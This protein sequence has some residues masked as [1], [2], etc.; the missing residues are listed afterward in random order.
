MLWAQASQHW[1][2]AAKQAPCTFTTLVPSSY[3]MM[4]CMMML[5]LM[6]H[7]L[8]RLFTREVAMVWAACTSTAVGLWYG[9]FIVCASS[10]VFYTPRLHRTQ[11]FPAVHCQHADLAPMMWG[12]RA[13]AY[14][15]HSN[16]PVCWS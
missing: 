12:M 2:T 15:Q 7:H 5:I 4:I 6:H 10:L 13:Y 14:M 3:L 9:M 11:P 1:T 16:T 8:E